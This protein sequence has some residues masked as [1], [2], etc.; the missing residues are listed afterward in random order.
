MLQE[1]GYRKRQ[2][3]L[4]RYLLDFSTIT[5]ICEGMTAIEKGQVFKEVQKP[6]ATCLCAHRWRADIAEPCPKH[7]ESNLNLGL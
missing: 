5:I 6:K 4:M 7:G 1:Q 3:E 2:P